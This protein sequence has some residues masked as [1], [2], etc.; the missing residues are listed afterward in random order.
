M[1]GSTRQVRVWVYR[2][3]V[4][5]RK[6]YDGLSA[7]VRGEMKS[8]VMSGDVYVF[9]GKDRRR[10]KA[11]MWDGTGLCLYAKRLAKCRFAA[12]WER[13]GEEALVLT[14]TELALLLEGS[15]CVLRKPVSPAPWTPADSSLRFV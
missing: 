9:V 6:Q 13:A 2:Q 3:A 4:D 5:M 15:E 1:I 12:P 10:A 7:L 14:M 11:V 8:D